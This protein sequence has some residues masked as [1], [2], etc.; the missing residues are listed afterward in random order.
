MTDEALG[1]DAL[2]LYLLNL[3]RPGVLVM[4]RAPIN[5]RPFTVD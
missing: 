1:T 3:C 4:T 2:P 5:G